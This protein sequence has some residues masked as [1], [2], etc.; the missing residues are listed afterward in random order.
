MRNRRGGCSRIRYSPEDE[1]KL[2][3]IRKGEWERHESTFFDASVRT[4]FHCKDVRVKIE[5]DLPGRW[6]KDFNVG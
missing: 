6:D 4:D 2:V 5:R 1:I 3:R